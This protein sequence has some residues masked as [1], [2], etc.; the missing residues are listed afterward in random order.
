MYTTPKLTADTRIAATLEYDGV[1]L[2]QVPTSV[3]EI[4]EDGVKVSD[5][6]DYILVEGL[7]A[8]DVVNVYSV[9]GMHIVSETVTDGNGEV[10]ITAPAGEVYII[11][12]NDKAVKIQH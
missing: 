5:N 2:N 1:L 8:G 6:G 7:K 4:A 3:I 12:I 11:R 10:R 9:N